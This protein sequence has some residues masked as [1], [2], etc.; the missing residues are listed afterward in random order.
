MESKGSLFLIIL[1][2]KKSR[3]KVCPHHIPILK[4]SLDI[5][6]FHGIIQSLREGKEP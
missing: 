1:G 2:E 6:I 3:G 5:E 4:C